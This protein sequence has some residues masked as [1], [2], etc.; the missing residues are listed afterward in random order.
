MIIIIV[1]R[2]IAPQTIK[3]SESKSVSKQ[4][5]VWLAQL[6]HL[7]KETNYSVCLA[8]SV[9]YRALATPTQCS[10]MCAGSPGSVPGAD[11]L[12]S[13]FHPSEVGKWGAI[14]M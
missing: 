4:V 14:S 10:L 13:G 5:S 9:G 3:C 12:D 2:I 1:I 6:C 8:S 7:A 11:K